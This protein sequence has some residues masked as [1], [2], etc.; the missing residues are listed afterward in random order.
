MTISRRT[1]LHGMGGLGLSAPLWSNRDA[2]AGGTGGSDTPRRLIVVHSPYGH[3]RDSWFPSDEAREEELVSARAR[4]T[5]LASIEGD[6][7]AAFERATWGNLLDHAL[8][9]DGIDGGAVVGHE[10][11]MGLTGWSVASE[12]ELSAPSVDQIIAREAELYPQT[13]A[14]RS[15]HPAIGFEGPT[16]GGNG[17]SYG[18]EGSS[19]VVLPQIVDASALWQL[20][21]QPLAVEGGE[22]AF[23]ALQ[24]RRLRV[25]DHVAESYREV[26]N[27]PGL[28]SA[29]R[30]RLDQYMEHLDGLEGSIA[31]A[32]YGGCEPPPKPDTDYPSDAEHLALQ[33]QQMVDLI[34]QMVKCDVTRVITLSLGASSLRYKNLGHSGHQHGMTHQY[35]TWEPG[36]PLE[37]IAR[38]NGQTMAS[39]IGQL[40]EV[41][42]QETGRTFLDNSLV[43]WTSSMGGVFNHGGL[44]MPVALFGA[45]GV[46]D[47]G[48]LVDFRSPDHSFGLHERTGR[49]GV[50][51]GG[52]L[53]SMCQAFGLGPEQ[54]EHGQ[55]GIGEYAFSGAL[56]SVF[57][58]DANYVDFAHGDKRNP[59]PEIFV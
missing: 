22:E 51:Y 14:F 6:L 23:D 35:D 34:A 36:G 45:K 8:I 20:A 12:D 33:P 13:P 59:L 42:D 57:G 25:V 37:D 58:G 18:M 26:R 47:R 39:L 1:F 29:E 4:R 38:F 3:P 16:H 19:V 40:D 24:A 55:Q 27:D 21:L 53:V 31:S 43:V 2:S 54:Y 56:A 7:S 17:I 10:K 15:L 46:I 32:E 41:E 28:S 49:V 44:S 11:A 50:N 48:A 9:L 5:E 30:A 52:V